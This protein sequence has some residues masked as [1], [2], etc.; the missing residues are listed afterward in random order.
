MSER[1]RLREL[2][3][4]DRLNEVSGRLAPGLLRA[5]ALRI[6]PDDE[7]L[8]E[9]GLT[10]RDVGY[11]VQANGDGILVPRQFAM[12]GELKDLKIVG[13]GSESD[14]P[15]PALLDVPLAAP[16]GG[17]AICSP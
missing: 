5:A 17:G 12:G 8:R 14:D 15:V 6:S 9:A 4:V 2:D 3:D 7:R 11:A 16:A 10:Q 13:P 1:A